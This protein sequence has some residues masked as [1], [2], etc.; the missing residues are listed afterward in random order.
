M[1][2]QLFE[3]MLAAEE[4]EIVGAAAKA[5]LTDGLLAGPVAK[6]AAPLAKL[7]PNAVRLCCPPPPSQGFHC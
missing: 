3:T 1:S 7:L 6:L 2:V 4:E 5:A